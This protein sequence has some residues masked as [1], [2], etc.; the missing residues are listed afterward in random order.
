MNNKTPKD[1]WGL[2]TQMHLEPLLSFKLLPVVAAMLL[3]LHPLSL[4][5]AVAAVDIRHT[6]WCC[7]S[8]SVH[9]VYS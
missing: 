8:R 2:E 4:G 5:G 7:R 1:T 9:V 6:T 3:S